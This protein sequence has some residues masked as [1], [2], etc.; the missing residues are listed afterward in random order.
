M[1]DLH[2]VN[3]I[4]FVSNY[5]KIGKRWNGFVTEC[6]NC[7]LLS[8]LTNDNADFYVLTNHIAACVL[9]GSLLC[10]Y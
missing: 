2:R 9:L 7:D 10:I 5:E 4:H 1:R 6:L 8:E 3:S